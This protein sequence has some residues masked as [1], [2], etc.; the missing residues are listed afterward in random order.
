MNR[1]WFAGWSRWLGGFSI[2]SSLVKKVPFDDGS[3]L[4]RILEVAWWITQENWSGG[5]WPW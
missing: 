1:G 3:G 5:P 2:L 4:W